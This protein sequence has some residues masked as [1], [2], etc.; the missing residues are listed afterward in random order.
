MTGLEIGTIMLGIALAQ[1]SPGPNM[2][3]VSAA[4]L[5]GGR[6]AGMLTASGIATG[7]FI[8]SI[9]FSF[10]IGTIIDAFPQ[11]LTAMKIL[12]GTYFL[13]LAAKSLRSRQKRP[14]NQPTTS[15]PK[16]IPRQGLVSW[17]TGLLVVL[18]NPKAAMMWVAVSMFLASAHGAHSSLVL[19]GVMAAISAMMVYGT[20]AVL[21]STGVAVRTY[22]R[23]FRV[24]DASFGAI[25]GLIGGR[26]LLDGLHALRN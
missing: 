6:R 11:T 12:G 26:L 15:G 23:F 20:Y 13:Y 18:T 24:I 1:V 5:S 3:A 21:F 16:I 9:L 10:G 22:Q 4:A 7:V 17:R 8:W 19:I 2:M 25:F 14:G